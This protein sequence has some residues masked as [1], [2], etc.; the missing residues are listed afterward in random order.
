MLP[1]SVGFTNDDWQIVVKDGVG[2]S[3]PG[4]IIE[5][6]LTL[7]QLAGTIGTG[8]NARYTIGTAGDVANVD[9]MTMALRPSYFVVDTTYKTAPA[10]S[11]HGNRHRT[12]GDSVES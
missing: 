12:D 3:T 1:A 8:A 4:I 9:P 10:V 5:R 11:L 2:T 6:R 7:R